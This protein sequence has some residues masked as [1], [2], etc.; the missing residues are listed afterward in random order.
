MA[1]I[2]LRFGKKTLVIETMILLSKFTP[3][4]CVDTFKPGFFES[5]N[6]PRDITMLSSSTKF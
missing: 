6:F 2:L 5:M 1:R 4:F 3:N